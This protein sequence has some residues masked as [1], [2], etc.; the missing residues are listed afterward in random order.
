MRP[1]CQETE[2]V[3]IARPREVMGEAIS[4]LLVDDHEM[5]REGLRR[6]LDMEPGIKVVGEDIVKRLKKE[7]CLIEG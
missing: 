1:A 4:V 7:S 2:R 5:A 3:L 6:L